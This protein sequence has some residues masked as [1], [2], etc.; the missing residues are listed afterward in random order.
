MTAPLWN[1]I[2]VLI[3]AVL[4]TRSDVKTR[5][6]PNALTFPALLAGLATHLALGGGSGL[7]AAVLG[8]AVAGGLLLPGWLLKWMGA[9]DVKLMAAIGAWLAFPQAL[10]A[11]L[12]SLV[13]GG[14]I[15]LVVAV[16]HGRLAQALHGAAGIGMWS[17][18]GARGAAAGLP[19]TTGVRFPF[20]VAVL[21][22]STLALWLRP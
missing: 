22:G 12:A 4:A 7:L 8:M 9:G 21:A 15:A 6:I 3:I 17:L 19:V 14:V 20:A 5:K 13:A 10:V 18:S 2:P 16:R 1:A 11:V